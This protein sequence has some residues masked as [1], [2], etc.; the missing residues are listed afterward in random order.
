MH[1]GQPTAGGNGV[2]NGPSRAT[3]LA[4]AIR[5]TTPVPA[6]RNPIRRA[7]A[8]ATNRHHG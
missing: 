6:R 2:S 1:A 5:A 8:C 7:V 3:G 4:T